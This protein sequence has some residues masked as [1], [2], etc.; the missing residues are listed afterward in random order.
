MSAPLLNDF[1]MSILP[2]NQPIVPLLPDTL[3]F[4]FPEMAVIKDLLLRYK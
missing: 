4:I 1:F 2:D 3:N